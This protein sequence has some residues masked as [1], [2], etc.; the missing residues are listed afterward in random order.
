MGNIIITAGFINLVIITPYK[1]KIKQYL[2]KM[3]EE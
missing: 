1:V 2:I 3:E